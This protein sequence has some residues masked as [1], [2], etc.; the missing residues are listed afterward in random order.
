MLPFL[1]AFLLA[2]LTFSLS[3][4]SLFVRSVQFEAIRGELLV[5]VGA[6]ASGHKDSVMADHFLWP[7]GFLN[8][9]LFIS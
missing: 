9:A 7:N 2:C 6:T 8:K 5:V 3:S 1:C 4:I